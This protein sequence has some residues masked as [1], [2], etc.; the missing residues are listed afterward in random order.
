MDV[1]SSDEDIDLAIAQAAMPAPRAARQY[2]QRQFT[3]DSNDNIFRERYR[4]PRE[5]VDHLEEKLGANLQ[6]PTRRNNPLSPRD[7]IKIFL[8]FLGTNAFYHTLRDCHGVSTDTVFRTVHR[9]CD[10]LFEL[11]N[12]YIKWPE[13]TDKLVR[14]FY[15]IAQ[16]PSVCGCL[17]GTHVAVL[18]PKEDEASCVNRHHFHSLN[19]MAVCGPDLNIFYA[20]SRAGGRWHDSRVTL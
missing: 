16:M 19:V 13:N 2:A 1:Y 10:A 3:E 5:V 9:V 14:D 7:Q 11:R 15:D 20:N 8:H 6:H 17:D 12:V 4:V 18:P